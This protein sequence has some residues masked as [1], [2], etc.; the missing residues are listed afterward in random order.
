MLPLVGYLD[1]LSAAPGETVEVK[2]GSFGAKSYRADLR[3]I[4]QGDVNPDGPG[5]RDEAIPLDLGGRRPARIQPLRPGSHGRIG[6]RGGVLASLSDFTITTVIEPTLLGGRRRCILSLAGSKDAFLELRLEADGRPAVHLSGREPVILPKPAALKQWSILVARHDARQ[7]MLRLAMIEVA[8]SGMLP[9]PVEAGARITPGWAAE[10]TTEALIGTAPGP[11]A[12]FDGKIDSPAV[13]AHALELSEV[14]ALL[15]D[16]ARIARHRRL[17]AHW[18]FSRDMCGTAIR[19]ASPHRLDGLTLQC[20]VRAM[21]GWRWSGQTQDWSQR[22][23][24]YTA[25]HFHA[26]DMT[27]AGWE[28]DFP[29]SLP[30]TPASGVYAVRLVPDERDEDAYYCVFAV[31]PPRD[32]ATGNSVCFL[33]P[34]ASYLAYANHRLGLDVPGTEIGMGRLVEIDRHHVFLQ[35]HPEVGFS[36]YET[37][38]DGSGVFHSS[39]LRPIVDMQ[40][41]V[42]GFLGGLGSNLW[43]FNADTHITGW[44]EHAGVGYDVVTDEDLHREGLSLLRRY[45]VVITGTHPEYHSLE[46]LDAL[47]GFVDRGGRLMYLGGNGFYWRISFSDAHPG[48]IECRRSEAG[49][50]PWEPGP[51]QFHHAFTGEYGGLWRRNGRP[52][53]RLAG[54]TMSSQGFDVSEPYV[55]S[56]AAS[57][58]R[59]SFMFEGLDATPGRP[60]GNFG[61]S[62]G[63]AAGL[64]IDRADA[65]LGTPAH[66]L[67]VA[68]SERH[69]DI[70]L[71]T[72]E[73]LLDPTPDWTG[74]QTDLVRADLTFFET[75]GGGAVFSTGSI[76][77]AGALAAEAYRNEVAQLTLN[78]LKRFDHPQPF[79]FPQ[80]SKAGMPVG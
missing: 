46:M 37:H 80:G 71:M 34:T 1:R 64:E 45:R 79:E 6:D 58:P 25:I 35:E 73:D 60:F 63:G 48:V 17:V 18:D 21:T 12:H 30:A 51:G 68:S 3:R 36:F 54:V 23:D 14:V 59:L 78:V 77:W 32:R 41:R 22:P 28:T 55:L 8:P 72:P 20:P 67:L 70:Y 39:R 7:G 43:Q 50:R 27:D 74:T 5:Y 33:L 49:I 16:P 40:P 11:S 62:G 24:L 69:T 2:V 52:S 57:D 75:S 65:S 10:G 13:F 38:A 15:C 66:A 42:K 76:A 53:G 61:L 29:V 56:A 44:L 9:A 4:I 47:Q 31:G 19:D 26:D